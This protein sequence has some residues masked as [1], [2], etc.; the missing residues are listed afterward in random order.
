MNMHTLNAKNY[1]E[2]LYQV[3]DARDVAALANF[4]HPELTFRFGNAGGITGKEQVL[5]AN[6]GFFASID[7]MSH[8]IDTVVQQGEQLVCDGQVNYIRQDGSTHSAQFATLLKVE[9]G[10]I[11][12]YRIYADL[13]E[14]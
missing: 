12:D 6:K 1:V 7:D 9:D 10:L 2:A 14:L 8:S 13:S 5:T 3:V 11:R 4:L